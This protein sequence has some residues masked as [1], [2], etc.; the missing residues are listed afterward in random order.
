M[1]VVVDV[2]FAEMLVVLVEVGEVG[3]LEGGV[4]VHVTVSGR[5]VLP[6]AEGH[7][8]PL[9]PVVGHVSVLMLM[10]HRRMAVRLK[11]PV[12]VCLRTS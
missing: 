7:V 10:G 8:R 9:A 6:F 1:V 5:Q 2:R 12:C 3:M 11:P 4:V